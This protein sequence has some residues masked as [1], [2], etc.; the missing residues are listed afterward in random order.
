METNM[1]MNKIEQLS[2]LLENY[3]PSLLNYT[4][5][6]GLDSV[7]SFQDLYNLLVENNAFKSNITDYN[8]AM[9][10]LAKHDP[11]L[12]ACIDIVDISKQ[13]ISTNTDY[14]DSIYLANILAETNSKNNFY[15]SVRPKFDELFP[16]L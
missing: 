1:D 5:Y 6:I 2:K 16:D 3:D 8:R 7:N 15:T 9:E 14:I 4:D 13:L 12:K 10:Y 11:T